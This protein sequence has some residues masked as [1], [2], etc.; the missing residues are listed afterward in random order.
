V[1]VVAVA[2]SA[3]LCQDA[4]QCGSA[5]LLSPLSAEAPVKLPLSPLSKLSD[6]ELIARL[7]TIEREVVRDVKAG[8]WDDH[9]AVGEMR[10]R[11]NRGD[12]DSDEMARA[13]ARVGALRSSPTW[14]RGVE[15]RI[16]FRMPSWLGSEI[17]SPEGFL[18]Y[19]GTA[20]P[21][22]T[23][24]FKA[25]C[26]T[27]MPGGCG[28][29][30]A[31]QENDESYQAM[32][33]LPPDAT[34]VMCDVTI[35]TT[36]FH[37]GPARSWKFQVSIPVHQVDAAPPVASDDQAL[38]SLIRERV[39]V[40]C[41]NGFFNDGASVWLSSWFRRP[42]E[43]PL[44]ETLAH[45]ELSLLEEE[46]VVYRRTECDPDEKYGE[47]AWGGFDFLRDAAAVAIVNRDRI[48]RFRVRVRGLPPP[49]G[50]NQWCR[51]KYWSGEF[52]L[53]LENVLEPECGIRTGR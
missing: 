46:K 1:T 34:S 36:Q 27:M 30:M 16:W 14:F 39:N 41:A 8:D 50:M 38:T 47:A 35:A 33:H 23:G 53:P 11:V 15:W 43:G 52:T 49:E 37:D 17:F 19:E 5:S 20:L 26:R 22:Y 24:A 2:A 31:A 42:H 29:A 25:T 3:A 21:T 10:T 44:S 6:D 28:N 51:T 9:P 32:G 4:V 12:I 48:E 40:S 18:N 13:F 45:L 7:P